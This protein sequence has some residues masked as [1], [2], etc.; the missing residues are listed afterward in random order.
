M[1]DRGWIEGEEVER[2]LLWQGLKGLNELEDLIQFLVRLRC[3]T[4]C[5]QLVRSLVKMCQ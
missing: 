4:L 5:T 1:V 2:T 3:V